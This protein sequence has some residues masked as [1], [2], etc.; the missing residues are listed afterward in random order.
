MKKVKTYDIMEGWEYTEVS[1]A[2]GVRDFLEAIGFEQA[3]FKTEERETAQVQVHA[4]KD[5]GPNEDWRYAIIADPYNGDFDV[6]LVR[7]VVE[8][9]VVLQIFGPKRN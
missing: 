7:D 6:I 4:H 9:A 3:C 1:P 5:D 2:P 8:M